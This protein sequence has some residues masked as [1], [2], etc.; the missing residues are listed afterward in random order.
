MQDIS[1][2]PKIDWQIHQ[3]AR[4]LVIK[5]ENLAVEAKGQVWIFTFVRRQIEVAKGKIKY[6]NSKTNKEGIKFRLMKF[7]WNERQE[8]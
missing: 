3:I 6:T 1:D 4:Y 2:V 7:F 5:P 8:K